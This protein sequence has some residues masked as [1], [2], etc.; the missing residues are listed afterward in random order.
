M[1]GRAPDPDSCPQD[2]QESAEAYLLGRLPPDQA[3]EFED[4]YIACAMCAEVVEETDRFV[5]AIKQAADRL[6]RNGDGP[7]TRRA[8]TARSG[9]VPGN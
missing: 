6:C 3:R 2:P 9:G 7:R 5:T 1:A 8:A 4:H